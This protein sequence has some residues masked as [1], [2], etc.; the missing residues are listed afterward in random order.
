MERLK[1]IANYYGLENQ[2]VKT[3]EETTELNHEIIKHMKGEQNIGGLVSEI[4][5]VYIL[6]SQLKDL[7]PGVD[8]MIEYK[9]GRQIERIKNEKDGL[10]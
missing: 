2:L 5:D 10:K 4:A 8:T 6:V 9:V 1:T 7:V 3:I